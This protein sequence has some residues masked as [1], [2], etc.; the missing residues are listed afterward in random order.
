[1]FLF[2]LFIRRLF[3]PLSWLYLVPYQG[4]GDS[5]GK[6]N[7]KCKCER[8]PRCIVGEWN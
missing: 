5:T 1:M 8:C 2:K 3:L 4:A 7:V 6:L